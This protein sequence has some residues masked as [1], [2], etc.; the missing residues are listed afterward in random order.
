MTPTAPCLV[1]LYSFSMPRPPPPP[2]PHISSFLD[3][4][5]PVLCSSAPCSFRTAPSV[6]SRLLEAP[7]GCFF[8]VLRSP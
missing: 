5:G 4:W 2:V 3:D 7:K 6:L 1:Q 8:F